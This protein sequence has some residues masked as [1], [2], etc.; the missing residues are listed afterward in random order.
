[1]NA[2]PFGPFTHNRENKESKTCILTDIYVKHS[3]IFHCL[4]IFSG[5]EN[6][7]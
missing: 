6:K 4:L 3:N 2:L 5:E 7:I 1:M